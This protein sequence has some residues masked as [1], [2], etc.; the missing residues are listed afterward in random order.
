MGQKVNSNGFRLGFTKGWNSLWYNPL[1]SQGYANML[2]EDYKI[3]KYIKGSMKGSKRLI[4]SVKIYRNNNGTYIYF[5]Y[6]T[7]RIKFGQRYK[8]ARLLLRNRLLKLKALGYYQLLKQKK[9]K[10]RIS[11][12]TKRIYRIIKRLKKINYNIRNQINNKREKLI[13]NEYKLK[14]NNNLIIKPTKE[15]KL[16]VKNISSKVGSKLKNTLEN[17][18]TKNK[19]NEAIKKFKTFKPNKKKKYKKKY[20]TYSLNPRKNKY[21]YI[22][23][24]YNPIFNVLKI[25]NK[26]NLITNSKIFLY[27]YKARKFL[28]LPYNNVSLMSKILALSFRIHTKLFTTV[29]KR[30]NN[31]FKILF[32]KYIKGMRIKYTGKTWGK[33]RSKTNSIKIGSIPLK[34][35]N[36]LVDYS[37]MKSQNKFGVIG[38]KVWLNNYHI[39][40]SDKYDYLRTNEKKLLGRWRNNLIPLRFIRYQSHIRRYINRNYFINKSTLYKNNKTIKSNFNLPVEKFIRFNLNN[41]S[42]TKKFIKTYKYYNS[43]IK[44]KYRINKIKPYYKLKRFF[45]YIKKNKIFYK[46]PINKKK[47]IV[48]IKYN[49]IIKSNLYNNNKTNHRKLFKNAPFTFNR[50]NNKKITIKLPNSIEKRNYTSLSSIK[51]RPRMKMIDIYSN[52]QTTKIETLNESRKKR[53]FNKLKNLKKIKNVNKSITIKKSRSKLKNYGITSSIK[54]AVNSVNSSRRFNGYDIGI[55]KYIN[56]PFHRSHSK[57]QKSL[58]QGLK[59]N[60]Y[61]IKLMKLYPDDNNNF[62]KSFQG[63]QTLTRTLNNHPLYNLEKKLLSL[64][65]N[66]KKEIKSIN[67]TNKENYFY[68]VNYANINQ[69]TFYRKKR[70]FLKFY[71]KKKLSYDKYLKCLYTLR[72][73][74]HRASS[75]PFKK[76]IKR[77][78][79]I[80][81]N[82][83]SKIHLNKYYSFNDTPNPYNTLNLLKTLFVLKSKTNLIKLFKFHYYLKHLYFTKKEVH[84]I[85][86]IM[87]LI[88]NI[89]YSKVY[90]RRSFKYSTR[91]YGFNAAFFSKFYYIPEIEQ[92]YAKNPNINFIKQEK[93]YLNVN[94]YLQYKRFKNK[95]GAYTKKF[96]KYKSYNNNNKYKNHKLNKEFIKKK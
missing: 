72:P 52:K 85:P 80:S 45:Y 79:P 38:I 75:L 19:L 62:Y 95:K 26:L 28:G 27:L 43:Y 17:F 84:N 49:S 5:S 67:I 92:S 57:I 55:K 66:R 14:I 65:L 60:R 81:Y 20:N 21:H 48:K 2:L 93:Y 40:K 15:N 82:L 88:E 56:N 89:N 29:F 1:H 86:S 42:Y 12:R 87:Q 74:N 46:I 3:Q 24:F 37:F 39:G 23:K 25:K 47:N 33:G 76:R 71:K 68:I 69:F 31:L 32:P 44:A 35:I 22:T 7:E 73:L 16:K 70:Y 77:H 83:S 50:H 4:D 64:N 8:R 91:K 34:S 78:L 41:K 11:I 63:Y 94:S 10:K 13:N 54:K 90:K 96:N 36:D 58:S 18:Y 6:R 9:I 30:Y 59:L 53:L 61:T 51:L